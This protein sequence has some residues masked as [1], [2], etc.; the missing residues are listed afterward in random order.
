[1]AELGPEDLAANERTEID[2]QEAACAPKK[3]RLY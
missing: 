1:M 2:A 3:H